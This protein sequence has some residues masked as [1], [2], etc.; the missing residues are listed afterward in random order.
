MWEENH[1]GVERNSYLG[2]KETSI[3]T[4]NETYKCSNITSSR[5]SELKSNEKNMCPICIDSII[6]T[7]ILPCEHEICRNCFLQCLSGNKVC[8]FCRTE[9]QGIKET[10][11]SGIINGKK[12]KESQ[13]VYVKK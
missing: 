11:E 5:N 3:A 4:E 13:R 9:I 8:P 12:L 7:H 10:S 1:T 2:G 6:D